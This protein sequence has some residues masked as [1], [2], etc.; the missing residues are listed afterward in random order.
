MARIPPESAPKA[1]AT[2]FEKAPWDSAA[3][4]TP[5]HAV[6]KSWNEAALKRHLRERYA[7]AVHQDSTPY[8]RRLKRT[9]LDITNGARGTIVDVILDEDEP[10]YGDEPT[11]V[12]H[13]MPACILV[14]LDRTRAT[15]LAGLPPN[16][17]PSSNVNSP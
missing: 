9:G 15:Q 12:L 6:R 13:Y 11:V 3:L 17:I 16:V 4:V 10:E 7:L 1:E 5:R 2:D 8:Q 14:E